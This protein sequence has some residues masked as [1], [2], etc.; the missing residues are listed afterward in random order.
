MLPYRSASAILTG[1]FI[2]TGKSLQSDRQLRIQNNLHEEKE[3]DLQ[4]CQVKVQRF[5]GLLRQFNRVTITNYLI[6]ALAL[7]Q[8][9]FKTIKCSARSDLGQSEREM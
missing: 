6:M 1:Y 2:S 9:V 8:T 7:G 5:R 3:E 4:F